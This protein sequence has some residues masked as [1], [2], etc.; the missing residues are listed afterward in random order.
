MHPQKGDSATPRSQSGFGTDMDNDDL[1]EDVFNDIQELLQ[2]WNLDAELEQARK[3][4][5]NDPVPV[6]IWAL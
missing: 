3:E 1:L 4:S 2:P 6:D 5:G